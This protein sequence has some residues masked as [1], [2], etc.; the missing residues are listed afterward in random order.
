MV[1]I[2]GLVGL[3]NVLPTFI[4]SPTIEFALMLLVVPRYCSRSNASTDTTRP[5]NTVELH[6]DSSMDSDF[7]Y[8]LVYITQQNV[9]KPWK[10]SNAIHGG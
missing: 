4:N 6:V 2:S 7:F 8:S 9:A 1:G 10:P 3:T 5:G